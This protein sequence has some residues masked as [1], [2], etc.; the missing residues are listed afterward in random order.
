MTGVKST[1][2][3]GSQAAQESLDQR[4]EVYDGGH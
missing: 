1:V 3:V 2:F 4:R